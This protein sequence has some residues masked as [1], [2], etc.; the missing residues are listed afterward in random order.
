M[1]EFA[2]DF[3]KKVVHEFSK[4]RPDFVLILGDRVEMLCVAVA[5]LY[6]GIPSAQL[7]GGE[8]TFS[9]DEVARHAIT[10]LVSLH[11]TNTKKTAHRIKRMGE[12]DW[13]IHVVGAPGIDTITHAKLPEREV[14]SRKIGL[15]PMQKFILVT[16]H[17]VTEEWQDAGK[18]MREVLAAVKTFSLPVVAVYP[19]IDTGGRLIIKELRKEKGN[20][21]F[22][23]FK[24]LPY[25]EFL[26]LERDAAVWVGNSSAIALESASFKTPAVLVGTRQVGRERGDNVITAPYDRTEIERAMR[27][28]LF[29]AKFRAR[30]A[31]VKNPWGDG[32]ASPRIVKILENLR[33]D[34]RLLVKQI[35]YS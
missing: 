32:K 16:E 26:S 35:T 24:S 9:A 17:P 30:L 20:P 25:K 12:E 4:S 19:N 6:L 29:D 7:Y 27:T 22:H 8:K 10:K 21:L 23:I 15:A 34:R 13:R 5:C 1:A 2:G 3:L 33:L 11:L 14:M 31:K 18:Q 28:A